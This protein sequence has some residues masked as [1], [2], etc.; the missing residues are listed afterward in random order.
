[1][2]VRVADRGQSKMEYVHNAQQIV[3]L[4]KERITKYMNKVSNDKRYKAFVKSSTY[5]VWNSPIYHAQMVYNF[6]LLFYKERERK[7]RDT[8]KL[9]AYLSNASKNLD[10]LE[11]STQTFYDSYKCIVKDKFI[12]LLTDKI[13]FQR[14]ILGGCYKAV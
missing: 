2:S 4:V 8:N 10:L 9:L 11:S 14:K 5:S 3:F 13:D 7:M 12:N 6:C 1:M